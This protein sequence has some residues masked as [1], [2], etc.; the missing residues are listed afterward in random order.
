VSNQSLKTRGIHRAYTPNKISI[1]AKLR[2]INFGG[3]CVGEKTEPPKFA[4][5]NV[6]GSRGITGDGRAVFGASTKIGDGALRTKA[7]E[8]PHQE[9]RWVCGL[10]LSDQRSKQVLAYLVGGNGRKF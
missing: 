9:G 10:Q 5:R 2:C 7:L 1:P 8:K 3:C 4:P 6:R